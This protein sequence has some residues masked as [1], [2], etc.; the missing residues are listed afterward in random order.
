MFEMSAFPTNEPNSVLSNFLSWD[1]LYFRVPFFGSDR[2]SRSHN[3][4][5]SVRPVQVCL[6][7]SIFILLNQIFKLTSCALQAV[8]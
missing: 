6:K 5:P 2:S 1:N 3:V 7:L 4:R 8:S